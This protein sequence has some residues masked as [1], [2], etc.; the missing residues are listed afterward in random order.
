MSLA[1]REKRAGRRARHHIGSKFN[2]ADDDVT[3]LSYRLGYS[4]MF[5]GEKEPIQVGK[6][7]H[8]KPSIPTYREQGKA[9]PLVVHGSQGST[10]KELTGK[11]RKF[12]KLSDL[13]NP[14][15]I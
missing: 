3:H 14:C 2:A 15:N 13:L 11:N 6:R 4:S 9:S 1:Y 12:K 10:I 5:N 8:A 7:M